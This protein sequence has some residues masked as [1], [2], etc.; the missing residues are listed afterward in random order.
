[1]KGKNFKKLLLLLVFIA[2]STGIIIDVYANTMDFDIWKG[3]SIFKF[4]TLQSNALLA[5]YTFIALFNING[6]NDN[7]VFKSLLSPFTSYIML[8]GLAFAILL[9]PTSTVQG[10]HKVASDILHYIVPPLMFFF[11]LIFEERK[12]EYSYVAKWLIYPV[13]FMIWGLYRA[14]LLDDYLYPFFD[15]TKFGYFLILYLMAMAISTI[16]IGAFLVF[17][18][19][20]FKFIRIS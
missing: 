17:V 12:L 13:V 9:A 6:L 20:R 2:A 16:A 18:K 19:K 3:L 14:F 15:P 7:P 1:M 11:W 10:L 4:F 8:T 5:I